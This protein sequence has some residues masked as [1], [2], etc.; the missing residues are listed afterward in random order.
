MREDAG[1]PSCGEQDCGGGGLMPRCT[2]AVLRGILLN[3]V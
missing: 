2:G 1:Q 3:F